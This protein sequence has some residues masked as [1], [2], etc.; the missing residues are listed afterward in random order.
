MN[1]GIRRI[2]VYKG[3]VCKLDAGRDAHVPHQLDHKRSRGGGGGEEREAR[4][5]FSSQNNCKQVVSIFLNKLLKK[6]WKFKFD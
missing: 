3:G 1:R 6:V 2:Y 5:R 4:T